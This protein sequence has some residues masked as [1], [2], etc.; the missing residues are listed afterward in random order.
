MPRGTFIDGL[1]LGSSLLMEDMP[2]RQLEP[3]TADPER[4]SHSVGGS[5]AVRTLDQETR[6]RRRLAG[7]GGDATG[8]NRAAQSGTRQLMAM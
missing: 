7:L 3:A 6:L 4:L 5:G 8:A 1:G 2:S